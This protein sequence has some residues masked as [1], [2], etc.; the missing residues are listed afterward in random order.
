MGDQHIFFL[1]CQ[2][3]KNKGDYDMNYQP[4]AICHQ[5]LYSIT[6]PILV[7]HGSS[8]SREPIRSDVVV[9]VV[10][11]WW[12]CFSLSLLP[13]PEPQSQYIG[14]LPLDGIC[15]AETSQGGCW[16]CYKVS[17][18]NYEKNEQK[19]QRKNRVTISSRNGTC[20]W[21]VIVVGGV[22]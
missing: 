12:R 3:D 18:H 13:T 6:R 22:Y 7:M 8:S 20:Y 10:G 16:S 4:S 1:P 17:G 15:L 19:T 9:V 5:Q 11:G 14:V 21:A 2:V